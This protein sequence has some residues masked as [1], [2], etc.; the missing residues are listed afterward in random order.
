MAKARSVFPLSVYGCEDQARFQGRLGENG[1]TGGEK[2]LFVV[3]CYSWF[4][5][6]DLKFDFRF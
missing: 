1:K 5:L 2:G 6:G 4:I 3:A